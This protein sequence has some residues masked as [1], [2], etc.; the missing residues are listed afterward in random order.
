MTRTKSR[1]STK[2]VKKDCWF[3]PALP[4]IHRA[5]WGTDTGMTGSLATSSHGSSDFLLACLT[6]LPTLA[7]LVEAHPHP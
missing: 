2:P 7:I 6:V 3:A 5:P 1:P 4:G